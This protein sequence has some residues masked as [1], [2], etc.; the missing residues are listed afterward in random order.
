M[1]QRYR[2]T[3]GESDGER[4][5]E[6]T[7]SDG[8][9]ERVVLSTEGEQ[10][11]Q[12]S[13][14]MLEALASRFRQSVET[15]SSTPT[16]G[17][18]SSS[19]PTVEAAAGMDEYYQVYASTG[20]VFTSLWNFAADVWEPGYRVE[21]AGADAPDADDDQDT[22]AD[23]P[24]PDVTTNEDGQTAAEWLEEEWLP[25]AAVLHG[26]KHNDFLTFGKHTTIQRWARGGVLIE[27]VRAERDDPE[28]MITGLNYIPPE[29]ISFVPYKHKPILVDADPED[30]IEDELPSKIERTRRGE[31]PAYI[32]YH[33]NAPR[34]TDRDPI[35]L[36]QRDVSRSV[37][38]GDVAG[39]GSQADNFWGTPVTAIIAEDVAGFK[40]I[41]R[42]KEQAIKNKAYGLWKLAFNDEIREYTDVDESG[43]PVE[44]TDIIGWSDAEKDEIARQIEDDMGP[45]S[46]LTHDGQIEMD[47]LDGEVPDLAEDLEFYVSNITSA[48]PSP[49]FIVGFEENIN[50]FVTERQDKRYQRLINEERSEV[51]RL[52]TGICQR[53]IDSHPVFDEQVA[54]RIE[55]PEHESPVLSLS[56]EEI[57]RM[58]TWAQAF[59]RIR[60]DIPTDMFA[61][62]AAL[63]D[64]ILQLPEHAAPEEVELDVDDGIDPEDPQVQAQ[65]DQIRQFMDDMGDADADG[66]GGGATAQ[67]GPPTNGSADGG[68]DAE[69]EDGDG[70]ADAEQLRAHGVPRNG[71]D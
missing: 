5:R 29:T 15:R 51:S 6:H 35:R 54:F 46:I 16:L 65:M 64:L 55:P 36:S 60:G 1:S 9:P 59:E 62:P 48:L 52:Y 70:D 43:Q 14:G 58:A 8:P 4:D 38:N 17:I 50:Q 31:Y 47:R 49:K 13:G 3:D 67:G 71:G 22:D 30:V 25:Q 34:P 66:D 32:Q 45:G 33:K 2:A 37:F 19:V 26:G 20:I 40:N 63:R 68:A 12:R 28:A 10:R 53:V 27:H 61:D 57:E 41:I 44:V 11:E 18:W 24:P 42:D 39:A 56:T 69:S 21:L 23:D 7:A